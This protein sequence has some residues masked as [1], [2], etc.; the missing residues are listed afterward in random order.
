[1]WG[2]AVAD[3]CVALIVSP[4]RLRYAAYAAVH[5]AEFSYTQMVGSRSSRGQP[6]VSVG[7]L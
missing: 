7:S 6:Q 5:N 4:L 2:R 1:M 3:D